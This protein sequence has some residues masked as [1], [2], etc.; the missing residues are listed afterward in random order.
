MMCGDAY[1]MLTMLVGRQPD[2]TAS[3]PRNYVTE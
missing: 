1:V 2:M 3:L